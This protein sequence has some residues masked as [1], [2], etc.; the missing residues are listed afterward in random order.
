MY[1]VASNGIKTAVIL[2]DPE[3]ENP[4]DPNY[5]DN[6]TKMVCW[7]RRYNLG[8]KHDFSN[9]Y[10]FAAHLGNKYTTWEDAL[11]FIQEGKSA[12]NRLIEVESAVID[13]EKI[14]P[15]LQLQSYYGIPG[16]ETWHDEGWR[17]T[18]D[19]D[20]ITDGGGWYEDILD[21]MSVNDI[22]SMVEATDKV[23]ILPLFLYDHSGLAMSTGSFVG[24][25]HHAEWDSGQVGYIYMDKDSAMENLAMPGDKITIAKV[26]SENEQQN[27]EVPAIDKEDPDD[28]IKALRKAGYS[29]VYKEDIKNLYGSTRFDKNPDGKAL[30]DPGNIESGS[31]FKKDHRLYLGYPVSDNQTYT[32][33]SIASYN[34]DLQRLTDENWKVRAEECLAGDVEVYDNYLRGEVYG[35]RAFE[36]LDEVDSCWGFNPG[37]EN[38]TD[39]MRDELSGW[40]EGKM[41]FELY[42]GDD[43]EIEEFLESNDFPELREQIRNRVESFVNTL[44]EHWPYEMTY[45]AVSSN[46]D[47]VLSNI[48]EALY[49]EHAVPT[50]EQIHEV[51]LEHAGISREMKP[52]LSVKD[53]DPGKD[54]TAEELMSMLQSKKNPLESMIRAAQEKHD[55]QTSTSQQNREGRF[56]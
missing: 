9:P 13:G 20:L 48:I 17:V 4:R 25:A 49:D 39:L 54:Y 1:Y 5:M 47:M 8:D 43:F 11:K 55:Q 52:K 31:V 38:V 44:R 18:K 34:P 21:G 22:L 42:Y 33:Q 24:R 27:V 30:I 16:H 56:I 15:H 53:L 28:F 23:A 36:G 26:F 3:P 19:L 14:G 12:N 50:S 41:D 37:S 35:F 51:M 45:E 46:E 2:P 32:L 6:I 10:H 40:Y 29:E 7:H